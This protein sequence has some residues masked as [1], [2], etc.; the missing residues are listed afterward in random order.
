MSNV[1]CKIGIRCPNGLF[2][3]Q[4][5]KIE[6]LTSAIN[7]ARTAQEKMPRA[8]D[9]IN[10]VSILLECRSFDRT[11]RNCGLCRSFSELRLETANLIVKAGARDALRRPRHDERG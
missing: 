2:D 1:S 10:E 6:A 9:L 7:M 5:T 11:N 3:A 8:H 4:E